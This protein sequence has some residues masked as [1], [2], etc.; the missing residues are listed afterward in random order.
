MLLVTLS[1]RILRIRNYSWTG[2]AFTAL[3]FVLWWGLTISIYIQ[4]QES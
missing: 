1:F 2:M 4:I 3:S